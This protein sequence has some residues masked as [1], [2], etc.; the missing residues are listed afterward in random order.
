MRPSRER[1]WVKNIR[2]L[3]PPVSTPRVGIGYISPLDPVLIFKGKLRMAA[4]RAKFHDSAGLRWPEN[5]LQAICRQRKAELNLE[6]VGLAMKRYRELNT[7]LIPLGLISRQRISHCL[8][9]HERP[10]K[11]ETFTTHSIAKNSGTPDAVITTF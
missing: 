1:G 3:G 8:S 7:S 9:G 2:T 11:G 5:S 6:Y 4:N 10:L